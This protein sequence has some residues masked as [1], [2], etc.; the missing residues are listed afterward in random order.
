MV[1]KV[2]STT[3]PSPWAFISLILSLPCFLL[4]HFSPCLL[5]SFLP[6]LRN[7]KATN[8]PTTI[9]TITNTMNDKSFYSFMKP[10][11]LFLSL[12]SRRHSCSQSYNFYSENLIYILYS[13]QAFSILR[14]VLLPSVK[15]CIFSLDRLQIRMHAL[16]EK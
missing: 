14:V 10:D 6:L 9:I 1:F 11:H 15:M 16:T 4:L 3:P 5:L 12:G 2:R 13:I 8:Q 7:E